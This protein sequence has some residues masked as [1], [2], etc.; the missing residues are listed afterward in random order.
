MPVKLKLDANKIIHKHFLATKPG[1]DALQV[2][3]FLDI[4][5]DDYNAME[6]YVS[7][8]ESSID[9]LK[10]KVDFLNREVTR[11]EAENVSLKSKLGDLADNQEVNLDNLEL[12]KRISN[13]EKALVR[14][15]IN[16][17]TIPR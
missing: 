2:D 15:G 17:N 14:L 6:A 16:P 11:V 4:V 13:L 3:T 8:A 10:A 9:D 12:L 1:Y 5:K 7:E